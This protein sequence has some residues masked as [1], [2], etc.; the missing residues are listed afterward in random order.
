MALIAGRTTPPLSE[1][2]LAVLCAR[3]ARCRDRRTGVTEPGVLGVGAAYRGNGQ[4]QG[5]LHRFSYSHRV[6]VSLKHWPLPCEARQMV[7]NLRGRSAD[8]FGATSSRVIRQSL[9]FRPDT[10]DASCAVISQLARVTA[11]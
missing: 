8:D 10:S 9:E 7:V 6:V 4:R 11:R 3:R 5:L 1:P 2:L